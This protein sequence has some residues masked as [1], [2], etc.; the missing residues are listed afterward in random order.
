[1]RLSGLDLLRAIAIAWVMF[2]HSFLV[3]GLGPTW[4]WLSRDGWM[5]VDLFFV[6]SGYLIGRQVLGPLARGEPLLLRDFYVR[7]AFRILPAFW[8]VLA[9]YLGVPA[10]REAPGLEAWW[11]FASFIVN[12]T[13][14]YTRNQAFSH[15]WS[16]CVE[17][18][19]YLVFPL[20]A[21]WLAR[22][23]DARRV[24]L[25]VGAMVAGGIALRAGV[26]LHDSGL[27]STRNWFIEDLYYPTWARLDGLLAGV[28]LATVQ[29]YRPGVWARLGERADAC[30]M[31]GV[32]LLALAAWVCANRVGLLANTLGWPAIA[33]AL[34]C[35]VAAGAQ[36]RGLLGRLRVPGAAWLATVSYS[37]YLVH[38]PIYHLV[39]MATG[40]ALHGVAAFAAYALA[41]LC[42]G[43]L[44]HYLVER[45][46]LRLRDRVLSRRRPALAT[47]PA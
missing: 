35:L 14:D 18:H 20:L 15:A 19:F 6:L 12:F 3:G 37:L 34:A 24:V 9:L 2:F 33:V 1:M 31:A 45:P 42:G 16:L 36:P 43:A 22:R 21:A 47:A 39:S 32:A 44:L 8:V 40:D 41:S 10:F 4:E 25:L 5:G 7:R 23:G 27:A 28:A 17:E 30:L 13:I 46:G 11:K 26:W 29:V 38:K